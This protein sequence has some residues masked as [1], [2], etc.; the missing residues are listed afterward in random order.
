M[1]IIDRQAKKFNKWRKICFQHLNILNPGL[2][3]QRA[4]WARFKRVPD[5]QWP[6]FSPITASQ[7]LLRHTQYIAYYFSSCFSTLCLVRVYL[8][9]NCRL[10]GKW[11][12]IANNAWIFSESFLNYK[13]LDRPN[14]I[15]VNTRWDHYIGLNMVFLQPM[16]HVGLIIHCS[17]IHSWVLHVCFWENVFWKCIAQNKWQYKGYKIREKILILLPKCSVIAWI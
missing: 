8:W 14:D 6:V 2:D 10:K 12:N 4:G 3:F 13:Y 9:D 15:F 5:V 11:A 1:K 17:N 16:V 7:C